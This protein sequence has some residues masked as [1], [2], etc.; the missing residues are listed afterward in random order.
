MDA[1]PSSRAWVGSGVPSTPKWA[2]ARRQ[3]TSRPAGQCGCRGACSGPAGHSRDTVGTQAPGWGQWLL[4]CC[5][6]QTSRGQGPGHLVK[7]CE[8]REGRC[9][10]APPSRQTKE[11]TNSLDPPRAPPSR[12]IASRRH[13]GN[14]KARQRVDPTGAAASAWNLDSLRS[15]CAQLGEDMRL[16]VQRAGL[17]A[18]PST[19]DQQLGLASWVAGVTWVKT[20][21]VFPEWTNSPG[22]Q[23]PSAAQHPVPPPH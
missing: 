14:P 18:C 12:L 4:P 9:T 22:E 16:Q 1:C 7:C 20:Q 8:V 19:L 6:L 13:T 15:C 23:T 3:R 17:L 2:P 10:R 11:Q 21:A 5:R